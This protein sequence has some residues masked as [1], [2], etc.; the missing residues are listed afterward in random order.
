M[1]FSILGVMREVEDGEG[2]NFRA[3]Y[4]EDEEPDRTRASD[5]YTDALAE[6]LVD[7]EIVVR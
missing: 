2:A 5:G 7:E 6:E 4:I 3:V 1:S